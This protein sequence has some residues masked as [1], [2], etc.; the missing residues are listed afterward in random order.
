MNWNKFLL[1]ALA[2]SAFAFTTA[3]R[4]EGRVSV[5]IG[6]PS[7]YGYSGYGYGYPGYGYSGYGNSGY[8]YSG[9]GCSS[10]YYGYRPSYY[11]SS[12]V[13]VAPTYYWSH[14]RRVYYRRHHRHW[15]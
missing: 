7:G 5:G 3:P 4:A 10:D 15:R 14:G 9:Y 8:G 1:I 11:R 12:V 6:F 2:I 13:Y